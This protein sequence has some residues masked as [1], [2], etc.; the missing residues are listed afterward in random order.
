MTCPASARPSGWSARTT[1]CALARSTIQRWGRRVPRQPGPHRRAFRH[2]WPCGRSI[3][4]LDRL[5][6]SWPDQRRLRIA[7]GRRGGLLSADI[8]LFQAHARL[9]HARPEAEHA[10]LSR[11]QRQAD[12]GLAAERDLD[13]AGDAVGCGTV[14]CAHRLGVRAHRSWSGEGPA[15]SLFV[16]H[17]APPLHTASR[18]ART[19]KA[20]RRASEAPKPKTTNCF[21]CRRPAPVAA[22]RK[23][24][25]RCVCRG[26]YRSRPPLRH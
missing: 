15:P 5:P 3:P 10:G 24:A 1:G 21:S 23:T 4:L 9:P 25:S 20:P 16:A 14:D 7:Q 26:C 22:S 6:A 2:H 8:D 19:K 12:R 18:P 11:H 17:S 13:C